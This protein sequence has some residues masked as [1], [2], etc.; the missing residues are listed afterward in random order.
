[1]TVEIR[2]SLGNVAS[3]TEKKVQNAYAGFV[4]AIMNLVQEK[5]AAITDAKAHRSQV[6]D[7]MKQL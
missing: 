6:E 1:M 2:K 5:L 3:D 7:F 4:S